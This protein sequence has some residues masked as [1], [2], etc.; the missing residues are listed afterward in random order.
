MASCS[1]RSGEKEDHAMTTT[2]NRSLFE[3]M[4]TALGTKDFDTFE[5]C[6]ADDVRLEWPFPVMDGF[7]VEHRGARWL[8]DALELS[9]RDFTP[10]AYT[11]E[12][13]H[14]LSDDDRLIAEYTSHS[15]YLPTAQPYSNRYISV[16]DF[17]NGRIVRW[18]E[19]V[20]PKI[21][22]QVLGDSAE[23]SETEG[24]RRA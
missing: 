10:Y 22:A 15:R 14:D 11:I 16:F 7:P 19:Y 4:L 2:A 23:W 3:K 8:R 5:A 6:L 17:A 12:A 18:R 9:F 13:V 1:L 21:V 24:A 20:N